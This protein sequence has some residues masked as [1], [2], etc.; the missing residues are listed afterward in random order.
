[1]DVKDASSN[2]R[3]GN[4]LVLDA[5]KASDGSVSLK[6]AGYTD[7]HD[8]KS[9]PRLNK[10]DFKEY[11]NNADS[12]YKIINNTLDLEQKNLLVNRNLNDIEEKDD[13]EIEEN[14]SKKTN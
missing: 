2:T 5:K 13:E 3:G 14:E 4:R 1:M 12:R 9:V 8:Y 10:S 11:Y 6:V 7:K